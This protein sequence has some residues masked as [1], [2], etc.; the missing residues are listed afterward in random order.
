MVGRAVA[1]TTIVRAIT[2]L[3]ATALY[4]DQGFGVLMTVASAA[5]LVAI[6]LIV[7]AMVEP[8]S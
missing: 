5:G 7:L 3:V 1:V 2:T 6:G 4:V 8:Q